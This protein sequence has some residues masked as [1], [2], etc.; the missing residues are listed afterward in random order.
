MAHTP[1]THRERGGQEY[2][3]ALFFD[4]TSEYELLNISFS[5]EKRK[6][7]EVHRSS[8]LRDGVKAKSDLIL[9]EGCSRTKSDLILQVGCSRIGA[10]LAGRVGSGHLLTRTDPTRGSVHLLAR[11]DRTRPDSTGEI[12]EIS[13]E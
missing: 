11:T 5:A 10:K 4:N 6:E 7:R 8:F 13:S 3:E 1:P 2:K 9:Q 12:S